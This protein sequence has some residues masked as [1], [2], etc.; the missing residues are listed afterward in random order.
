MLIIFPYKNLMRFFLKMHPKAFFFLLLMTLLES[1]IS[2]LTIISVAPFADFLNDPSLQD[3]NKIT[4]RVVSILDY[5]EVEK[6]LIFFGA[7]F[8][9]LNLLRS[10][11]DILLRYTSLAIKY[12][13][14]E[15]INCDLA[16]SII[17]ANWSYIRKLSSGKMMNTLNRET[18]A[19]GDCVGVLCTQISAFL[20]FIVLILFPIS[21][22]PGFMLTL[23]AILLGLIFPYLFLQKFNYRIGKLSTST[24]NQCIEKLAEIIRATKSIK[25][26]IKEKKVIEDYRNILRGHFAAAKQSHTLSHAISSS[27]QSLGIGAVIIT[28]IIFDEMLLSELA[29]VVWSMI[30]AL[31]L[32]GRI[33]GANSV[34]INYFPSFEQVQKIK[35]ES[36]LER[37][38]A[39]GKKLKQVNDI[40]FRNVSYSVKNKRIL[41][42]I[43]LSFESNSI[44]AVCGK[45]GSGKTT[46]VEMISGFAKPT[47]GS[48]KING[49]FLENLNVF[50]VRS[51]I[52]YCSQETFLFSGSI[53]DNLAFVKPNVSRDEALR[54]LEFAD[55]DKVIKKMA[56]GIDSDIGEFGNILSGGERQKIGI[57]RAILMKPDIYIFDETTSSI[58]TNSENKIFENIKALSKTSVVIFITHN[59]SILNF[60]DTIYF[61][62]DG[63]LVDHGPLRTLKH[64]SPKFRKFINKALA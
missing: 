59:H 32:I 18:M 45:S 38:F 14:I 56:N 15:K 26:F 31:P 37:E 2:V 25:S 7:F 11:A 42:D 62:E 12:Q 50:S 22:Y 49:D 1:S 29:V 10:L 35:N 17:T 47:M 43:N 58:D 13:M 39:S 60:A 4:S 63:N 57:A 61:L 16:S 6:T 40:L 51:K 8:I 3:V 44:N 20:K 41:E 54:A 21:L 55:A 28:T 33:L 23:I 9:A 30:Q 34:I 48:I 36:L 53:Y 5:Y 19:V 64:R 46:L 52:A 24:S 27:Y